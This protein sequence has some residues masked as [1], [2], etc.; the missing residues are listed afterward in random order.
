MRLNKTVLMLVSIF[1]LGLTLRLYD[2]GDESFWIDEM[3]AV[4]FANL[5]IAGILDMTSQAGYLHPPFHFILLHYWIRIL[6]V[7]EFSVRLL[8]LLFGFSSIPVVYKLGALIFDEETGVIASLISALSLFQIY[9]SQEA[10]NYIILGFFTLLSIYFFI[11]FTK[12]ANIRNIVGYTIS[13]ILMIY[14]HIFSLFVI[15]MQNIYFFTI[16]IFSKRN[17]RKKETDF[18]L[19]DWVV[20]Q[21]FII[22]SF[23]SW[24]PVLLT[25][26]G[27]GEMWTSIPTAFSLIDTFSKYSGSFFV[28]LLFLSLCLMKIIQFIHSKKHKIKI[29]PKIIYK[30]FDSQ[31]NRSLYLISVWISALVFIPFVVSIF[32]PIYSTRYT[33][34]ASFAFYILIASIISKL[35][36]KNAKIIVVALIVILS[37]M[38]LAP[39][40]SQ[41]NKTQWRQVAE[42]IDTNANYNDLVLFV[43]GCFYR[44]ES[45]LCNIWQ[46]REAVFNYYSNRSDL[47]REGL[48]LLSVDEEYVMSS[49]QDYTRVWAIF[50]KTHDWIRMVPYEYPTEFV[51]DTLLLYYDISI[52]NEFISFEYCSNQEYVGIDLYLFE[53]I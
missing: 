30:L 48:T 33:I 50:P 29:K 28:L 25:Q 51:K 13:S 23:S 42:Y 53:K 7:S 8:S 5:E 26:T 32:F 35:R 37:L 39:Y 12:R 1:V 14:T 49:V 20:T 2:L 40:Y 47:K 46:N 11:R 31:Q 45:V 44:G 43:P 16:L 34:G 19:S 27:T 10:R 38:N 4:R 52:H 21:L 9:Y 3:E 41:P 22:L 24:I 17:S 18:S 15:V 36:Y 6:G